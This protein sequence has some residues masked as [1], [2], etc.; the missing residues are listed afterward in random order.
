MNKKTL[1]LALSL[2]LIFCVTMGVTLA[3]LNVSTDP[4]VNTFIPAEL[5]SLTLDEND[6]TDYNNNES[7]H[8][9]LV[10]P[11]Q[12][13]TKDP[14]VTFSFS[15]ENGEVVDAYVFVKIDVNATNGWTSS[16]GRTFTKQVG[17]VSNGMSF[18]IDT[19]W[20]KLD[21][22]AGTYVYYKA[23]DVD[24]PSTHVNN[25]NV[26]ANNT[27]SVSTDIVKESI[28]EVSTAGLTF[29]AYAIQQAS[30][31]DVESAWAA[32]S[33]DANGN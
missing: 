4:V 14:R 2:M 13:I 25:Q 26:I 19:F 12:S 27:I 18:T 21:T 23:V 32:V 24:V 9:Y 8:D 29:T 31:A 3:Y 5:G 33:A 1:I 17:D 10:V 30:F 28:G 11:G 15:N 16:D 7:D 20:T 22:P 6:T